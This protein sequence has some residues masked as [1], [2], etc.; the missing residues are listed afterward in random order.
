MG[1]VHWIY[2]ISDRI[3]G[4][5][6]IL[7]LA[8]GIPGGFQ[9]FQDMKCSKGFKPDFKA[10]MSSFMFFS[11]FKSGFMDF[12]PDFR[13]FRSD[14]KVCRP[15]STNFTSDFKVFWDFT[16]DLRYFRWG[17]NDYRNFRENRDFRNFRENRDFRNFKSDFR[18][19]VHRISD[20]VFSTN[21]LPS[22]AKP[23]GARPEEFNV[24][25]FHQ[26]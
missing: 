24:T 16:P 13:D 14:F 9:H 12:S 18:T 5:S 10:F 15:V 1:L 19:F 17:F 2:G 4:I 7:G 11:E 26:A 21:V 23:R 8:L 3:S 20:L 25:Y 6:R 22:F